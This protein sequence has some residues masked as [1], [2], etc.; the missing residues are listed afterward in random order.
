MA[1]MVGGVLL[2]AGR[3]TRFQG[4]NKLLAEVD[5]DPV[6]RRAAETLTGTPLE[7]VVAVL[8]HEAE[9]VK[10]ALEGLDL[11]ARYNEDYAEGQSTS[12]AAG[13]AAARERGWDAAVF[14]LGDMP[15]VDAD[16]VE[17]LLGAYAQG[18]GTVLAPAYE[19][20]RGNPVLFDRRHFD[21]L[22]EVTGDR[23][24][25][26][27]LEEAGTLVPVENPGIWRDIDRREDLG[28]P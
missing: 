21:A 5:G 7:G 13:V 19:G 6:V 9:A 15:F 22:V 14:A 28:P 11:A 4:G 26:D 12:V 25:R 8:G 27:I 10:A 17:T 3:G 18:T 20:T 16:T 24:G 23:G 2:A 1:R